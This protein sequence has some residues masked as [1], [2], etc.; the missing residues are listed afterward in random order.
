MT[1]NKISIVDTNLIEV[2]AYPAQKM[3]HHRMKAFCHGTAFL[4]ALTKGLDG[5]A[6]YRATKWLSDDRAN[7]ALLSEDSEW[8]AKVWSQRAI[9]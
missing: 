5:M 7:G 3:I 1:T 8:A 2:W 9:S 4:D 6:R